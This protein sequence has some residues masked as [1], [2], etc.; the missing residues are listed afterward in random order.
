MIQASQDMRNALQAA[1]AAV[2]RSQAGA[3]SSPN[4]VAKFAMLR[5]ILESALR[6]IDERQPLEKA[7]LSGLSKW[8]ADWI[9]DVEDPLLARLDEMEQQLTNS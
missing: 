8:V 3:T 6:A 2:N 4:A 7:S 9:P 1:L 5:D